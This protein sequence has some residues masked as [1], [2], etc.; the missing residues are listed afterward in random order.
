MI[1]TVETS[2]TTPWAHSGKEKFCY[3]PSESHF[4][5][6]IPI[7]FFH[8]NLHPSHGLTLYHH[9]YIFPTLSHPLLTDIHK[10]PNNHLPLTSPLPPITGPS[11]T[12]PPAIPCHLPQPFPY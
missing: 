1:A 11:L 4:S 10:R 5:A 7:S 8:K 3:L 9:F 6:Y 2:S 12:K